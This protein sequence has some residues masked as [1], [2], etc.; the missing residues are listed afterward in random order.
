MKFLNCIIFLCICVGATFA[1]NPDENLTVD[2][3]INAKAEAQAHPNSAEAHYRLSIV[4]RKLWLNPTEAVKELEKAISLNPNYAEAYFELGE[5]TK[6]SDKRKAEESYRKAIQIKAD[7]AEAYGSL[8]KLLTLSSRE[9][10]NRE[11]VEILQKAIQLKPDNAK[12]YGDLGDAYI[13]LRQYEDAI[14]AYKRAIQLDPEVAKDSTSDLRR[15]LI[16]LERYAEAIE[17]GEMEVKYVPD[18]PYGYFSLGDLYLKAGRIEDAIEIYKKGANVIRKDENTPPKFE[19]A[20][21]HFGMQR[22][23]DLYI[24]LGRYN[25]AVDACKEAIRRNS[26]NKEAYWV[27]NNAY[28]ELHLY[29]EA[30]E[31]SREGLRLF[32]ADAGFYYDLGITYLRAGDK[33]SAVEQYYVLL[34]LAKQENQKIE[35]KA[36]EQ[37]NQKSPASENKREST[38]EYWANKLQEKLKNE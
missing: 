13:S 17:A 34:D 18:N 28:V 15:L 32:P 23:A 12:A 29:K 24:R 22:L 14:Q 3:I 19:P 36:G 26:L 5:S 6:Y 25:D 2:Q 35:T 4:Y 16:Q 9:E 7:F 37:K 31:T 33:K 30:I 38:Y 10:T 20:K 21:D 8:G 11:V 27:L 1:Q